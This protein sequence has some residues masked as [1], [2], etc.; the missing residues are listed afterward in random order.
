MWG[1]EPRLGSVSVNKLPCQMCGGVCVVCV[2]N[3]VGAMYVQPL[4]Q[5][6]GERIYVRSENASVCVLVGELCDDCEQLWS[7]QYVSVCTYACM[8]VHACMYVCIIHAYIDSAVF[9]CAC[10]YT[11]MGEYVFTHTNTYEVVDEK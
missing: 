11:H 4:L 8:N 1:Q 10:M 3:I 6:S 7:Q 2:C 5:M 9:I